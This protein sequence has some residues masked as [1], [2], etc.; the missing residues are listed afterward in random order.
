MSREY[1]GRLY[2]SRQS[3]YRTSLKHWI[4]ELK[5]NAKF[6]GSEAHFEFMRLFDSF[7]GEL[8]A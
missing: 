6:I 3:G 8:F 5:A 4:A 7:S 2:G 1:L